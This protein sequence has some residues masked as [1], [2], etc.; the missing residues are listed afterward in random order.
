MTLTLFL[1]GPARLRLD[2]QEQVWPLDRRF[3]FLAYLAC[4]ADWV[5]RDHLQ[6]LFWSDHSPESARVNLRQL[7]SRVRALNMPGLEVERERLCWRVDTDVTAF[8]QA[9]E[10]RR[11]EEALK[12]YAGPFL[13]A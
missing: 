5:S 10:A 1:L 12:H 11:W 6:Y 9:V 7:L 4:R 2:G 13:A 3:Q 8:T